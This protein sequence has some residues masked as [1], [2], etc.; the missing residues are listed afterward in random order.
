MARSTLTS[1]ARRHAMTK[2]GCDKMNRIWT[3]AHCMTICFLL[4]V[5]AGVAQKNDKDKD[6]AEKCPD[7]VYKSSE[8]KRKAKITHADDP[9]YTK[10]ARQHGIKGRVMLRAVLCANGKV[11]NIEVIKGLPYGLTEKAI[12]TMPKMRFRPAEK[13]GHPVSVVILREFSFEIW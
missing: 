12:E 5:T 8:V 3:F 1:G 13:D 4:F 2:R 11:T 10:E 7:P 6:E 9:E